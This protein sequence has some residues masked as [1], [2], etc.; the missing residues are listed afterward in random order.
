MTAMPLIA[1]FSPNMASLP[2]ASPVSG[3]C[4]RIT[5]YLAT[6]VTAIAQEMSFIEH[7][8]ELRRRI[9]WA[10]ASVAVTFGACWMFSGEL[11]DIASE[12]IRANPAVTLSVSR[13]QDIFGLHMKVAL[14]AAIFFSSPLI[15]TQAWLFISPG[16]Y[17]HERRWAVPFVLSAS[18][19]F[20]AGGAFGYYVAFPA[21]LGYL[22]D[23]IVSSRLTPIIDAVEYFDLFFSIMVALGIVFQIPAIVFVLSRIGIV[24]ARMLLR[25]FKHAVLACVVVSAVITP[26]TDFGN[27]LVVA[28]PMIV[29]YCVGIG[30]AAIFGKRRVSDSTRRTS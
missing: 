9:L 19:L 29:L 13:P 26:T 5:I 12:P 2:K 16:L 7:L 25:Y 1:D 22:L 10:I 24:T 23:W 15:L 14:V 3:V 11:Y 17:A 30:V 20:I 21:A 18:A 8:E 27:M 4:R 6:A 28:G